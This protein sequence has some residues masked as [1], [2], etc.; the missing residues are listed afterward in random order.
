MIEE[1]LEQRLLYFDKLEVG[2]VM[3]TLML[4]AVTLI[5]LVSN[6]YAQG[7]SAQLRHLYI[8]QCSI[9]GDARCLMHSTV[10][11]EVKRD[12][13]KTSNLGLPI[14]GVPNFVS[15]SWVDEMQSS[16]EISINTYQF[17]HLS[18]KPLPGVKPMIDVDAK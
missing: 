8:Y 6:A 10:R 14:E 15:L 12:W 7:K 11:D 9:N 3:R 1:P 17:F 4:A 5:F 16:H 13:V 18:E 2:L